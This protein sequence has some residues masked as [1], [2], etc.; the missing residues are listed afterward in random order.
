MPPRK[1]SKADR[2]NFAYVRID[3]LRPT[4]GNPRVHS[5]RQLEQ[6]AKSIKQFG[7]LQPIV[8]DKKGRIIAGHGRVEAAEMAGL[9][10]VPA[11]YAEHLTDQEKTAYLIADNKLYEVGEWNE[12]ALRAAMDSLGEFRLEV[13]GFTADQLAEL[14]EPEHHEALAHVMDFDA[15]SEGVPEDTFRVILYVP[16][17]SGKKLVASLKAMRDEFPGLI[18]QPK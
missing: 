18:V 12:D 8:I 5:D 13:P 7:F 2:L 16:Q 9:V 15:E 14:M 17:E 6:I 1:T 3:S 10:E 4:E 11:V